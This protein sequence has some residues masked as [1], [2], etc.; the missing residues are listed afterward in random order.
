MPSQNPGI[1]R[2][3]AE[4]RNIKFYEI[5]LHAGDSILD[6]EH[7][8]ALWVMGGAMNVW[9]EDEYPWLREEKEVIQDAVETHQLPF[10][11]I[12]LGHQLLAEALGG[13]VDKSKSHEVGLFE[14]TPTEAGINHPLLFNLPEIM[15]W[16]NVHLVEVSR[17][18]EQA[19]ILAESEACK[20]HMMQIGQH[21]YSC[22]FH[23][24]VCSYTVGDWMK[25]PG[26]PGALEELLGTDGLK[27]FKAK[28]ADHLPAHNSAAAQLFDNW[29]SLV[30]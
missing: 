18:P 14:V 28:I 23:P 21:A 16:V 5:D 9:E 3:L 8:D 6:I 29:I 4:T 2:E 10:L 19:I 13:S 11:G 15:P 22:Q 30:F 7:F 26:I 1:F 20:N 24:E 27:H 12:C 17:A 25:I